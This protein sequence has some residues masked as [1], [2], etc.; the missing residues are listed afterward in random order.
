MMVEFLSFGNGLYNV[1]L[2][3]ILRGWERE[4]ERK[5]GNEGGGESLES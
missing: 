1:K 4:R 2:K 5:E 3:I